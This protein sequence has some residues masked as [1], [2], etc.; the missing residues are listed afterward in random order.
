MLKTLL[1]RQ[2][3]ELNRS[4]FFNEKKGTTRTAGSSFLLILLYALL[5]IVVI[6]GMFV[7]LSLSLCG[8]FHALGMDWFYF[9]IIGSLSI[10]LG[11]FGSVFNTY[12]SLY[13]SK[14]NDLLLSMPI[15]VRV[16]LIVRLLG[17]YLMGLMFS[18]VVIVPATVVYWIIVGPNVSTVVCG[19]LLIL[20]ISLF[21]LTLSCILGWAVAKVSSKF[22]HKSFVT[23]IAS[24]VFFALYYFFYFKASSILQDVLANASVY[25][26]QIRSAAYPLY[27]LGQVGTGNWTA[28]AI[29]A[30]VIVA[31][32]VLT[33]WVLSRN[34]ITLATTP[35]A[36]AKKKYVQT[37]AKSRSIRQALLQKEFRRFTS[38]ANY[39]LNCG[40]G[41][42]LMPVGGILLLIKGPSLLAML[43]T[44]LGGETVAVLFAALACMVVS[45]ND[46]SAASVSLEGKGIWIPQSLPVTA[47]QVLQAKLHLHL[48]L[49]LIPALILCICAAIVL[50]MPP[51]LTVEIIAIPLLFA[52]LSGCLGLYLNLTHPNLHWTNEIA[53]VKQSFSVTVTLFSGWGYAIVVG[54]LYFLFGYHL[55]AQWYLLI[56]LAVTA[57]AAILLYLWLRKRGVERFARL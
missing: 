37:A 10:F 53:P 3:F 38:S 31:L 28:T 30:V 11:V 2:L 9:T 40:L 29:A 43:I 19:L 8:P 55:T 18:A 5:M 7:F 36:V 27:L 15:P 51:L 14:D 45:M 22:K 23:V 20:L 33:Y 35:D 50:A 34:F 48:L 12:A 42:L 41:I 24:L 54:G 57:A 6:G 21:V 39:M 47:W 4:F 44:L 1:K 17:V 26:E 32:A 46:M 56:V 13:K 52:F 25:G 49:T 16:I